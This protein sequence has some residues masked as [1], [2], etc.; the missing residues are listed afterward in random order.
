[1]RLKGWDNASDPKFHQAPEGL[2]CFRI[3][4]EFAMKRI[5]K[6]STSN[7]D[8]FAATTTNVISRLFRRLYVWLPTKTSYSPRVILSV[9]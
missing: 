8:N 3:R 6:V 4:S 2:K 5:V 7:F 1:M 9:W